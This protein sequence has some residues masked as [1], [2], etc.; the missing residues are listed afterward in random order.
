MYGI[1]AL[2]QAIALNRH[3]SFLAIVWSK[4]KMSKDFPIKGQ[5][6]T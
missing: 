2:N 1:R 3:L 6:E 4:G 5:N